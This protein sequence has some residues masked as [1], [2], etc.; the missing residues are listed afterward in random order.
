MTWPEVELAREEQRHELVLQGKVVEDR[1]VKDG[2][3]E[4]IFKLEKLNFLQISQAKLAVLPETLGC[5]S[6]LTSLVLKGNTLTDIPT[7]LNSLR[8]LKLLDLSMNKITFLPPI[9][10]LTDLTTLNLSL[11]MLFGVLDIE[12]IEKCQKLSLVDLSA[13]T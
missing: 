13:N 1:V 9:P 6:N 4:N 12:G 8:K 10:N 2:I 7:S 3:D 5:L 11:N